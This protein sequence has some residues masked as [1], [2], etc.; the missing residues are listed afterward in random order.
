MKHFVFAQSTKNI[1][2][3]HTKQTEIIKSGIY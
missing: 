3:K 2:K 1:E